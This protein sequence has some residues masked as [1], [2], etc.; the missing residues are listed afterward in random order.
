MHDSDRFR[1]CILRGNEEGWFRDDNGDLIQLPVV[2]LLLDEPTRWD[3]VYVLINRLRTLQQAVTTFFDA[4]AQCSISEKRLSEMDWQFLQDLEVILEAPHATQQ[5]LSSEST[6]LLSHAVPT[7]EELINGWESIGLHVPHC[8]PIIDIGLILA[9]KYTDRMGATHA[10]S[11]AMFI[12][13]AMRMSWMD[14]LWEADRVKDAKKFIL[15]LMHSKR[16]ENSNPAHS[17]PV[18]V[19][20]PLPCTLG[21]RHYGLPA[22]HAHGPHHHESGQTVDQEFTSYATATLS[23]RG[24]DILTFWNASQ[25]MFPTIFSIAMDYAPVQASAV[26]CKRMVKFFLKKEWLN[27]TKGWAASQWDMEHRVVYNRGSNELLTSTN[28]TNDA[29]LRAIAE[30]ECDN[31]EDTAIIYDK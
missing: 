24:T 21:S 11:V 9:S 4:W 12:D 22:V 23:P 20:Q 26:P 14:S 17:Q 19:P 28:S 13:P 31:I 2:E 5:K 16:A 27:F 3:S 7:F 6:P 8:K 10:Y 18:V 1:D 29:L 25:S 30:E 15:K